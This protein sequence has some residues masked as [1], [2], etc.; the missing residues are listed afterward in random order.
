[1]RRGILIAF[2]GTE[3]SGKS[4]QIRLAAEALE[5]DGHP[6]CLTVEPGGT[7][8]GRR[9]REVLLGPSQPVPA[10]LAEL[11]L[12][13]ADRAQHV[14]EIILPALDTGQVVLTDRYSASTIAYQG[15]GRGIDLDTVTRV[16]EWARGGLS[17]HLTILLD[18]PV[19]VGL[20]RARG[21]DRF[22]AELEAFHERVRRGFLALAEAGGDAWRV[23]DATATRAA[24]HAEVL[25]AV[26]GCLDS[27]LDRR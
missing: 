10:P 2:E 6:L 5:R 14:S 11:F 27:H 1:V 8:L 3:G 7:A 16:D 17:P 19:R 13:L 12:Y 20:G 9:L 15:Y 4:T 21:T 25:A 18:C 24:V 23:I 26:R 22:H